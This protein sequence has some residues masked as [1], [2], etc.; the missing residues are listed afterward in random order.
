MSKKDFQALE[1]DVSK[2]I[3]NLDAEYNKLK[4]LLKEL[5]ESTVIGELD[6]RILYEK[7]PHVFK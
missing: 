7:F 4:S 5:K 6:Y 3:D 1:N 2:E